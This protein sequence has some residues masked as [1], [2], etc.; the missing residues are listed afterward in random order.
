MSLD[1]IWMVGLFQLIRETAFEFNAVLGGKTYLSTIEQ[2]DFSG[3]K[4]DDLE[5]FKK[6][7]Y[8]FR[9]LKYIDMCDCGL[10]NSQMEGADGGISKCEICMEDKSRLMGNAH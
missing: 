3:N 6:Q 4:V 2:I 7:L 10:Q 1:K 9:S 5:I 8:Y